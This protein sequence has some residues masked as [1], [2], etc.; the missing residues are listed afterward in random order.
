MPTTRSNSV[1]SSI[2]SIIRK[3]STSAGH[4]GEHQRQVTDSE[5]LSHILPLSNS[6]HCHMMPPVPVSIRPD[7][8]ILE[9]ISNVQEARPEV[10]IATTPKYFTVSEAKFAE[11]A[12]GTIQLN[13][14]ALLLLRILNTKIYSSNE[15]SQGYQLQIR[16]GHDI[17]ASSCTSSKSGDLVD[18]FLM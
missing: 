3:N 5:A 15:R 14:T 12:P 9:W 1:A 8:S 10:V 13:P 6:S 18:L 16:I 7:D 11:V 2:Y 4:E 17:S